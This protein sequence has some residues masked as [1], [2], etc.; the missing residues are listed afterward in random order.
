[1]TR[2]SAFLNW[3]WLSMICSWF[4]KNSYAFGSI[5]LVNWTCSGCPFLMI[6]HVTWCWFHSSLPSLEFH[7]VP[8]FLYSHLVVVSLLFQQEGLWW[9]LAHCNVKEAS[10]ASLLFSL[11]QLL[12]PFHISCVLLC[13]VS[14]FTS[15]LVDVSI[16]QLAW[17]EIRRMFER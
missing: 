14:A 9:Q 4:W 12:A 17:L 8:N 13:L 2:V 3:P 15:W 7:S 10:I 5:D 6:L 16:H 11:L 1:M